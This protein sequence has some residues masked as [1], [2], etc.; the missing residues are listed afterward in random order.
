MIIDKTNIGQFIDRTEMNC[1]AMYITEIKFIPDYISQLYCDN[2]KLTSL[3]PLPVGLIV[4]WCDNNKLTKLPFLPNSLTY[5]SCINNPLI[6]V[7][8][9]PLSEWIKQH[10]KSI[11]RN[12]R[13]KQLLKVN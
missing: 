2:N 3:P 8:T 1:S 4:L 12:N 11:N 10:N 9:D 13:L 6:N 5:L 7:P